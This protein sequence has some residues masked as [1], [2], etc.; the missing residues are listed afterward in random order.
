LELFLNFVIFLGTYINVIII[1]IYLYIEM[2][3]NVKFFTIIFFLI[4]YIFYPVATSNNESYPEISDDEFMAH[5]NKF[6]EEVDEDEKKYLELVARP[7]RFDLNKDRKISREEIGKAL[8]YALF[9]SDAKRLRDM[10]NEVK[11]H[12]E[13]NI[14]L[15]MKTLN[16]D[17]FNY[18]QF[19]NLMKNIHPS[20]FVNPEVMASILNAKKEGRFE[21]E[22]D[23]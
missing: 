15:F 20:R 16:Q 2:K 17:S 23:L 1:Y 19:A 8:K 12:V 5:H 18:K 22:A 4:I 21:G 10:A 7:E 14:R 11:E 9:P 3:N 6:R 13:N